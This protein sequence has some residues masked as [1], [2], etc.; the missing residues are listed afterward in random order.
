MLAVILEEIMR[1]VV[2]AEREL[3]LE[4]AEEEAPD[5]M[6]WCLKGIRLH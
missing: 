1:G 5:R 3:P 2:V 6:D 4:V